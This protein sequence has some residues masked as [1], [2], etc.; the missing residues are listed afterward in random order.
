MGERRKWLSLGVLSL[1]LLSMF[2][3]VGCGGNKA[4]QQADSKSEAAPGVE[5]STFPSKDLTLVVPFSPG[6]S[7]DTYARLV[8]PYIQRHLPGKVNVVVKNVSGGDSLIGLMEVYGAKPDGYTIGLFMTPGQAVRQVLGNVQYDLKK[9]T[10]LGRLTT[11]T[12][13]TAVAPN[14]KYKSIQS[15][16]AAPS[17]K[18]G[19]A[20]ISGAIAT[21][22]SAERMGI[23]VNPISH[24]GSQEAILSTIRGDVDYVQFPFTSLQKLISSGELIPILVFADKRLPA[25]PDT[26]TNIEIGYPDLSDVVVQDYYLGTAPGTPEGVSKILRQAI[27]D[28]LRDPELLAASEKAKM[29]LNH[30]DADRS[31]ANITRTIETYAKYKEILA[32]YIK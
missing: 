10:W 14:S 16:Q 26:P 12:Y 6:G 17:V 27:A 8:A 25:I 31:M 30:A 3:L 2:L 15:L 13:A 29:P 28:A 22:I 9:V 21:L 18:L 11:T 24:E 20:A 4:A 7:F 19:T 23:K 1:F 32:R 5:K